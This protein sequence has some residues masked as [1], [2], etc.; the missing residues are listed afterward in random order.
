MV[1]DRQE[2]E[3]FLT[4]PDLAKLTRE[5]EAAWR[6]RIFFR[7]I[8]FVKCGRSVRVRGEDYQAWIRARTVTARNEAAARG[9]RKD[10]ANPAEVSQ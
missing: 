4:V 10:P 7:Q 3:Q 2:R 9:V 6:K 8:P 5:S 1:N